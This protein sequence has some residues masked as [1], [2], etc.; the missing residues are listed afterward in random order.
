MTRAKTRAR[1][2]DFGS[3][4]VVEEMEPVGFDLYGQHF[5][6]YKQINGIALLRFVKEA[7]AEDGARATQ[8]LLDIFE[9][10]MRD[11]EYQRFSALCEDPDTIVPVETL[12]DIISF[13]IE[14]YT[15]RPTK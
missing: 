3:P 11:E 9:R 1:Q 12:S 8:A 6:C 15:E 7:N 4:V 13:L 10:V 2:K 14:V 5:N